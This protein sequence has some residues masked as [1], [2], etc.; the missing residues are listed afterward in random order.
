MPS[1]W[2]VGKM[3]LVDENPEDSAAVASEPDVLAVVPAAFAPFS[4][5]ELDE[6]AR[7]R[8]HVADFETRHLATKQSLKIDIGRG[9]IMM[10]DF[11]PDRL[12]GLATAFR[13]VGWA[14]EEASF[15]R[16]ANLLGKHAHAA[17]TPEAAEMNGWLGA[18][19]DLRKDM[20]RQSRFLGWVLEGEE[21]SERQVSPEEV[22]D[23]FLNGYLMHGDDEKRKRWD[24][25]GGLR[26]PGLIIIATLTMWDLLALFRALDQVIE[27]ILETPSLAKT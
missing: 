27:R 9:G 25:L 14:N 5:T 15:N 21:G 19:H 11:D 3:R 8:K 13:K 16:V 4:A 18:V 24:D 6:L 22:L 26:S 1:K 12:G 23:L 7:Y 20:L 2:I 17:G 10:E